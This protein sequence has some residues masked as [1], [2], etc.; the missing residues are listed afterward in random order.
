MAQEAADEQPGNVG[1]WL[2]EGIAAAK[3][4]Q[5][6]RARDLLMRIVDQ[7]ERNVAAWLWLSGV[8]DSLEDKEIALENVLAVEPDNAPARKGL[9]W[10]RQQMQARA[11]SPIEPV[12]PFTVPLE[13][14]PGDSLSGEA[15]ESPVVQRT[16]TPV[17]PAAELLREDFAGREPPLMAP[18]PSPVSSPI[19]PP[20]LQPQPP[21]ALFSDDFD[22]EYLC[23]YCASPTQPD[24][25]RCKACGGDLWVRFRRLEKRS[26]ALWLLAG[27]QFLSTIEL[28]ALPLATLVYI[29]F[30]VRVLDPFALLAV[31]LGRPTDLPPETVAAVLNALPRLVFLLT[32]LPS[33]ISGVLIVGLFLRWRP[34]FYLLMLDAFLGVL[35]AVAG[36]LMAQVIGA[37]I[38]GVSLAIGRLVL[39]FQTEDDFAFDKRRILLRADS[40]LGNATDYMI[41]ADF[42]N[43]RRVWA[44]A[45]LHMRRAAGFQPDDIGCRVGLAVA[46]IRIRRYDLAEQVLA[47]ARRISPSDPRTAKLGALLDELRSTATQP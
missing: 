1:D 15:P 29:G 26:N 32:A 22:D 6:E 38:F 40:G 47:E 10:V 35:Y 19:P 11:P 34:A 30:R 33:V 14:L 20:T 13:T 25:K 5:R 45:I 41:R 37:G 42:Y 2:R 17:S 21:S 9:T 28:A 44:L 43:Q 46:Y 4:G 3:A 36:A 12:S 8:V 24:D 7:D 16:H 27:L 39:V 31:Y 23:P 18:Q